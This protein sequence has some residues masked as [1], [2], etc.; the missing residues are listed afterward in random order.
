[1]AKRQR[2]FETV[3]DMVRSMGVVLAVVLVTVLI[4]IRTH[5]QEIRVVD[6]SATLT[7]A[8]RVAPFPVLAPEKLPAAWQATSGDY[9]PPQVTGQAG[10]VLWHVGYVTPAQQYAGF[11]QTND[12]VAHVLDTQIGPAHQ[13]GTSVVNGVTWTRWTGDNGRHAISVVQG[14]ASLVVH[15][16][17]SWPELE[18]LAA[19]LRTG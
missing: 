12:T 11:E 16:T 19:A 9:S 10:V 18:Q 15:G 6:Y 4:T 13:D 1:M 17:A 8:R 5:G 3:G 14:Q 7:E 2:G